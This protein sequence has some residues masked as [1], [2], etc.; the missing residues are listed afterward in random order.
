MEHTEA[1]IIEEWE[2]RLLQPSTRTSPQEL[3]K[4]LADDF[5]EFWASWKLYYKSG[6]IERLPSST[7]VVYTVENLRIIFLTEYI[8]Q[9]KYELQEEVKESGE[10]RETFR[11][12]LWRKTENSWQMFFHQGTVKNW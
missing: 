8:A 3:E 2:R 10:K 11:T 1:Y 5:E 7:E 4:L 9:V 12:S 6:I